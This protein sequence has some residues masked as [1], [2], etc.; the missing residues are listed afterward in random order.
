MGTRDSRFAIRDPRRLYP[1]CSSAADW[2]QASSSIFM[3]SRI[4][5]ATSPRMGSASSWL[6]KQSDAR[7][8]G[9]REDPDQ[10]LELRRL[11]EREGLLAGPAPVPFVPEIL[12]QVLDGAPQHP[13]GG[14]KVFDESGKLGVR[15][16]GV[17]VHA[18]H[19][20]SLLGVIHVTPR[21][22]ESS[23]PEGCRGNGAVLSISIVMPDAP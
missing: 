18:D 15:R 20:G 12:Q 5:E 14:G 11:G 19:W 10:P 7:A 3:S 2:P 6:M 21:K 4:F 16:P 23:R 9:E 17:F 13:G 22:E 1:A 8:R